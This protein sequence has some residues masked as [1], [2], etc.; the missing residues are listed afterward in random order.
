MRSI[1]SGERVLRRI[2]PKAAMQ[3]SSGRD[4]VVTLMDR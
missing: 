3:A 2:A 4:I 1:Q